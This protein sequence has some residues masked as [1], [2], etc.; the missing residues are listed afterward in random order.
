[1]SSVYWLEVK[2]EIRFF[3]NLLVF[4]NVSRKNAGEYICHASNA[5]GNDS[6]SGILTVHCKS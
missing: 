5:C 4:R 2:T 6:K 3:K 1:M